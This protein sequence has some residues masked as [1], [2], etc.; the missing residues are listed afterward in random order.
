[1]PGKSRELIREPYF[2]EILSLEGNSASQTKE[3]HK[4]LW[5]IKLLVDKVIR[6]NSP[7]PVHDLPVL[8]TIK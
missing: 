3:I 7:L 6:H 5:E 8:T 2:Q 4:R 1:M